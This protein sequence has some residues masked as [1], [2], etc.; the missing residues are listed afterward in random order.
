MTQATEKIILGPPDR[1]QLK[2]KRNVWVWRRTYKNK[3][4][5]IMLWETFLD[6]FKAALS[7]Q[8]LSI[9]F[10]LSNIGGYLLLC[11]ILLISGVPAVQR[12]ARQSTIAIGTKP[13]ACNHACNSFF[14]VNIAS[15][16]DPGHVRPLKTMMI[17][18]MSLQT[19]WPFPSW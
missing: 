4:A 8:A 19:R 9:Y 12:T 6:K 5:W 17:T 15:G 14:M 7:F 3:E 2:P 18:T 11:N 13:H 1:S 10:M 16:M